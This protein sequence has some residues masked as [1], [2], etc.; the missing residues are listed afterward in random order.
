M[1]QAKAPGRGGFTAVHVWMIGFVFLWLTATVL[2][3]WL[4]TDQERIVSDAQKLRVE[5]DKLA[6]GGDKSLRWYSEAGAAASMAGLLEQQRKETAMLA[7]GEEAEDVAAARAKVNALFDLVVADGLV[8]DA[9]PYQ[10]GSLLPAMTAL[11]EEF[12]G[13]HQQRLAAQEHAQAV[14]A[15]LRELTDAH[16]KLKADFDAAGLALKGQVQEIEGGRASYAAARDSEIDGFERKMDEARQQF[17]RDVQQQRDALKS[18]SQ[19][20]E[21]LESRYGALQ[22]KLGAL[23]IKPGELLT[24]RTADGQVIMAV[25]ADK[26]VYINLGKEQHVTTGLQFAVYPVSGISVDGQAKGRIEVTRIHGRVAECEIVALA[27]TEVIIVGDLI[28]NP[29]YDPARPLRFVVAGEFDLNA[30]GIDDRDGADRI[31]GLI[32][33]WGG[34]I[35]DTFSDRADF[36]IVG[37]APKQPPAVTG[38]TAR[39]DPAAAERDRAFERELQNYTS[40]VSV[41]TELSIPILTQ[42]V[43]LRFLGL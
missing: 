7:V 26:I 23:Q 32:K 30:D 41:A 28:A 21:T 22:A 24:A 6:R 9:T 43:L 2:L 36:V 25:P 1:A 12:K 3:V 31:K 13:E 34:E 8:A 18:E 20:R 40:V 27:P 10:K 14:D 4:Y 35:L 29:V 33:G 42:D 37:Y 38:D 11:Y 16:E 5:N 17:S 15:S 19:R 39:R